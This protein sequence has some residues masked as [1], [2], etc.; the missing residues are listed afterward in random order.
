MLRHDKEKLT[1]QIRIQK[2]RSVQAD[3]AGFG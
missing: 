1:R 3:S 2:A